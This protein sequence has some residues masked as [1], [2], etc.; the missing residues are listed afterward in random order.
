[1]TWIYTVPS[2]LMILIALR[3][4]FATCGSPT[5]SESSPMLVR[6]RLA[7]GEDP[8]A[9]TLVQLADHFGLLLAL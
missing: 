3:D 4:I 9:I 5:T 2:V 1:M 8:A 7:G 6:R